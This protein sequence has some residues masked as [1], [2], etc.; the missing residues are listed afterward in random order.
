LKTLAAAAVAATLLALLNL[1]ALAA[2]GYSAAAN[3]ELDRPQS[4]AA[5]AAARIAAQ[6]APWSARH[7]ALHGWLLA[8]NDLADES[9]AAYGKAL[10]LAPADALLW[11]EYAQA[12]GR[13]GRFDAALT[14]ALEK[15]RAL[16]PN[17]PVIQ[18]T[19]AELGLAYYE[20]GDA[21][22]RELWVD[23]MREELARN[24]RPF[25]GHVL[26]RGQRQLFCLELAPAVGEE[27]WCAALPR[28]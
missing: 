9:L 3:R 19:L 2:A 5:L 21:R 12:L 11:A 14:E 27:A 22:Q 25:L 1:S 8:E 17:S 28:T 20:H 23:A 18:R 4:P 15:A 10:R 24:R 7:Q 16:A 26:T 6:L 13:L